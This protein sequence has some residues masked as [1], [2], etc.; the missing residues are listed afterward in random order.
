MKV[1]IFGITLLLIWTSIIPSIT[2]N[3]ENMK[4]TARINEHESVYSTL[5]DWWPMFFHDSQN[6]AATTSSGPN[7]SS[8]LWNMPRGIYADNSHSGPIIVQGKLYFTKIDYDPDSSKF[9]CNIFCLNALT[10]EKIWNYSDPDLGE[11]GLFLDSTP[12]FWNGNI[13]ALGCFAL[14]CFGSFISYYTRLLCFNAITGELLWYSDIYDV[15]STYG[16]MVFYNDYIYF[17]ANLIM[18]SMP[19]GIFCINAL[20]GSLIWTN[21]DVKNFAFDNGKIF[22][23]YGTQQLACID[24]MTGDLIW[25]VSYEN[26]STDPIAFN[27]NIYFAAHSSLQNQSII[28]LNED[29]GNQIWIRQLYS[30]SYFPCAQLCAFDEKIFFC[31]NNGT[32]WNCDV[33]C[34]NALTGYTIWNTKL[35]YSFSSSRIVFADNKLFI[36]NGNCFNLNNGSIVCLDA[37][38]GNQL[39]NYTDQDIDCW[40]TLA[41]ADGKLYTMA[42]YYI[43]DPQPPDYSNYYSQLYCFGES[44]GI[45]DLKIEIK[46]GLGINA[47]ITNNGT[48]NATDVDWQIH[49]KG[50]ILGM[51]NKTING[52][53]DIAA[54][55]LETVSTGMLLGLGSITISARVASIEKTVNGTQLF[56]FS[57]V[58]K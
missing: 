10:G 13:Y 20:N 16:P 58:K 50:G 14:G 19:V 25:N 1:L 53:I 48:A 5:T 3:A 57:M 15:Y 52:T 37:I 43:S 34:I 9:V 7:S 6:T 31:I 54:G 38:T 28:C 11:F 44:S 51:I 46:G 23:P 8:I 24:S 35:N 55:E 17:Y 40:N 12:T 42:Y 26:I 41:V 4:A 33:F 39:W 47:V 32:D 30:I 45:Y 27:G 2:G 18:K 36:A 29:T 21:H 22:S 56:I 49:V